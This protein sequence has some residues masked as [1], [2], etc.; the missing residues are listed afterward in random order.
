MSRCLVLLCLAAGLACSPGE[1]PA[2]A[3]GAPAPVSP[4][5]T[6]VLEPPRIEIGDTAI[7][8]IAVV[9]PPGWSVPALSLPEAPEGVWILE[10]G[11]PVVEQSPT[12][13]IH[14][15]RLRVRARRTG[16]FR[17][18]ALQVEAR[19]ER[20]GAHPI[21]L[22]ERPFQVVSVLREPP[23]PRPPFSFREPPAPGSPAAP[24]RAAAAGAL[25]ALAAVGLV[26]RVRRA[27]RP[28][29]VRARKPAESG[30]LLGREL[31]AQLAAAEERARSDPIPA[32]DQVSAALRSYLSRR[33]GLPALTRT[34]EELARRPTPF[35]LTTR[36]SSVVELLQLL[37]RVRFQPHSP[38]DARRLVGQA[39]GRVRREVLEAERSPGEQP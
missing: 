28:G 10:V 1:G 25:L 39:I 16:S 30:V 17:W 2:A 36:W 9:T 38:G 11:R 31:E 5:G 19:D 18:P 23:G 21:T 32:A 13:W 4:R 8:E 20:G 26:A 24:W 33:H 14:R 27:R 3:P 29:P 37:D 22:P 35:A 12:C 34:T 7:L 15:T 6:V